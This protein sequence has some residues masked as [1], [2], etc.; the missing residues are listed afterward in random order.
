MASLSIQSNQ[1]QQNQSTFA[2]RHPVFLSTMRKIAIGGF[3]ALCLI[4]LFL[5]QA[6]AENVNDRPL[7][8]ID[9]S[10]LQI[11]PD[12]TV[13][14]AKFAI[15]AV[16]ERAGELAAAAA[17]A[18]MD[19]SAVRSFAETLFSSPAE[20]L[21][22]IEEDVSAAEPIDENP[23]KLDY[24]PKTSEIHPEFAETLKSVAEILSEGTPKNQIDQ[25]Q[26]L[27]YSLFKGIS[28]LH[29]NIHMTILQN[30]LYAKNP[31]PTD[32]AS[33]LLRAQE[34]LLNNP[35]APSS[36]ASPKTAFPSWDQGKN[37]IG[38]DTLIEVSHGGGE[39]FLK[40][41]FD[42][43]NEGYAQEAGSRGI[44]VTVHHPD[45]SSAAH[46]S[47]DM[48]YAT[49]TPLQHFDTP[50]VFRAKIPARYL[51]QV[52]H[53]SYEAVLMREDAHHLA[54]EGMQTFPLREMSHARRERYAQQIRPPG[55]MRYADNGN[56][57]IDYEPVLWAPVADDYDPERL[58][59][60]RD[61][62]DFTI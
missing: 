16:K 38:P 61:Y 45:F 25:L 33:V 34:E 48:D 27:A 43:Q 2:S 32:I 31:D 46:R 41:F 60:L 42:G 29:Q 4:P 56:M 58:D 26:D 62:M 14:L 1:H 23:F 57:M 59:R 13:N 21:C 51:R 35:T 11:S 28:P 22:E 3:F 20:D 19:Q 53:N 52:N 7:P 10:G 30:I 36:N 12:A 5:P 24:D 40:D 17:A 47:R 55:R 37:N 54:I 8:N 39:R 50:V 18:L 6:Q 49:R 44:F 15:D 9:S